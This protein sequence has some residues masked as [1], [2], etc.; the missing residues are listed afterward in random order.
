MELLN[1]IIEAY[2]E[3]TPTD[4]FKSLGIF[5]SDDGDGIVYISKW[6]YSKPLPSTLKIGK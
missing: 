2:P 1:K 4:S 3:I 6:E 5:L